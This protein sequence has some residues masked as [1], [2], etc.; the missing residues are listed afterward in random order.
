VIASRRRTIALVLAAAVCLAPAALPAHAARYAMKR[1]PASRY[2]FRHVYERDSKRWVHLHCELRVPLARRLPEPITSAAT[3]DLMSTTY[4]GSQSM[5]SGDFV[6]GEWRERDGY[7]VWLAR[8]IARDSDFDDSSSYGVQLS[9]PAAGEGP[10][11][12]EPMEIFEL[13]RFASLEPYVWSPWARA[14]AV[15]GGDFAAWGELHGA[16]ETA[17]AA[18]PL[19]P[20]ELRCRTVLWE[21]LYTPLEADDPNVGRP[22]PSTPA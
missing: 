13:P 3:G 21:H 6:P 19:L 11:P 14:D 9:F 2:A 17:P 1:D 15:R 16:R 18:A 12:S 22:D 4:F 8:S 5:T 7:R 10:R 20:F